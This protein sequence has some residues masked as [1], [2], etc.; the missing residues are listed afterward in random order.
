MNAIVARG[1][2]GCDA[3]N[4]GDSVACFSICETATRTDCQSARLLYVSGLAAQ[5]TTSPWATRHPRG[6]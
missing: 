2:S 4:S 6:D 1:V 5:Q 3:R